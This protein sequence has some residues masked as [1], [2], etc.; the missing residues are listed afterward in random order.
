MFSVASLKNIHIFYNPILRI[1]SEKTYKFLG[2]HLLCLELP[3]PVTA[4]VQNRVDISSVLTKAWLQCQTPRPLELITIGVEV[5]AHHLLT[6][7]NFNFEY[8]Y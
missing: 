1:L 5:I 6:D 7:T 4:K 2:I 8:E 3:P